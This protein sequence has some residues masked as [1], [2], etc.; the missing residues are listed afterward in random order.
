LEKV[1]I[2]DYQAFRK[3]H[4]GEWISFPINRNANL[5]DIYVKFDDGKINVGYNYLDD[6][7]IDYHAPEQESLSGM[8]EE[9]AMIKNKINEI[10][11]NIK[12]EDLS[13]QE[14]EKPQEEIPQE[15]TD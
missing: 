2:K 13:I 8:I 1:H 15:E 11:V 6:N 5:P 12:N 3:I 4:S 10:L 9:L 7:E 14:N